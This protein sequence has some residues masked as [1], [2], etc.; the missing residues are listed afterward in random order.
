VRRHGTGS[1]TP[2][3]R[4]RFRRS[5]FGA[6]SESPT[7]IRL[8]G[9]RI[10]GANSHIAPAAS[11]AVQICVLGDYS[12]EA[13]VTTSRTKN[14]GRVYA[15][16]PQH[17]GQP[18]TCLNRAHASHRSHP[19]QKSPSP[20]FPPPYRPRAP[21]PHQAPGIPRAIVETGTSRPLA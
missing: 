1:I 4:A 8:S 6:E 10:P 11:H 12:R 14:T 19:T 3:K 16:Q 21:L 2:H 5:T 13:P 20:A 17:H 18:R 15:P 7:I 9:C